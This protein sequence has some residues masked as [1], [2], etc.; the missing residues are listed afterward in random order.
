MN[1][2]FAGIAGVV[3]FMIGGLWYGVLF[4][5]RWI[6][7]V[8]FTEE[9]IA[10]KGNGKT[11]MI[12]TFVI[13]IIFALVLV[14]VLKLMNIHPLLGAGLLALVSTLSSLKNYFFEG[15]SKDLIWITEAYRWVCYLV[16]GLAAMLMG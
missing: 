11:E 14:N 1:L 5:E 13:E 3:A 7:A 12:F 4:K 6:K 9:E 8:G 10:N 16:V 2:L 15:K